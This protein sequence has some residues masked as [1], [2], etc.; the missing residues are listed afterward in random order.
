MTL[1]LKKLEKK[2]LRYSKDKEYVQD[3]LNN[4]FDKVINNEYISMIR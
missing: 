1:D 2:L 4:N 3:I